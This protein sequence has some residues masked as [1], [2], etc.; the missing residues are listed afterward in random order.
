MGGKL[1]L[2]PPLSSNEVLRFEYV[3]NAWVT[4]SLGNP[5]TLFSADN[6]VCIWPDRLMVLGLK[7]KYFEVK[8]F[9][10]TAYTRDFDEELQRAK[11]FDSPAATLS[12][13]PKPSSI[14]IDSTN[15]PDSGYGLP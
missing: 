15:I 12:M 2:W 3:S 8:G 1:A 6:D 4:D 14:L 7:M 5:K 9:D 11:S 13:A 10:A